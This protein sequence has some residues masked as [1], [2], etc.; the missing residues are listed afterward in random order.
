MTSVPLSCQ[1]KPF[2]PNEP[3]A[4]PRRDAL[5]LDAAVRIVLDQGYRTPDLA[6]GGKSAQVLS[7][8]DMGSHVCEALN[9]I[10]DRRQAMHAV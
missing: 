2:W 7:T 3:G 4:C 5:S 10:I 6:R 8:P 9:E 1:Q